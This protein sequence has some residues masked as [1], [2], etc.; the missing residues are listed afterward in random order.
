MWQKINAGL[1][2]TSGFTLVGFVLT[3]VRNGVASAV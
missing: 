2:G 3:K 1:V